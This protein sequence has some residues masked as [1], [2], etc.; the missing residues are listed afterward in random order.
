MMELLEKY[1][2]GTLDSVAEQDAFVNGLLEIRAQRMQNSKPNQSSI[3][4]TEKGIFVAL[5]AYLH[6]ANTLK[7]VAIAASLLLA[8]FTFWKFNDSNNDAGNQLMAE[9]S[10]V[11]NSLSN[12]ETRTRGL[13]LENSNAL[14]TISELYEKGDFQ[15]IINELEGKNPRIETENLFLG[16]SY[17]NLKKPNFAAALQHFDKVKS[18]NYTQDITMMKA[19]CHIGLNQKGAARAILEGI[20][21]DE[22]QGNNDR[23]K[24]REL[25]EKLK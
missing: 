14:E 22:N 15:G 23:K 16:L 17:A 8:C 5:K 1:R 21:K 4:T 25:L 9:I 11:S 19:M 24:A 12:V 3:A 6:K 2:N 18:S 20:E 7:Y 10:A 13:A